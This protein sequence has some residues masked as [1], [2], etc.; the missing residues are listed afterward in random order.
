MENLKISV[1][2]GQLQ[3]SQVQ[4]SS[5]IVNACK[6][7]L[8]IQYLEAIMKFRKVCDVIL[9]CLYVL[10]LWQRSTVVERNS[11]TVFTSGVKNFRIFVSQFYFV[12]FMC[13]QSIAESVSLLKWFH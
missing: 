1:S 7:L 12:Q 4:I 2:L 10:V 9:V 13:L 11:F 6:I 3:F 5:R 8:F